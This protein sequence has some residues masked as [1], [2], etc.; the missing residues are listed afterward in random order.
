MV[1]L[2]HVENHSTSIHR[3][4]GGVCSMH[5]RSSPRLTIHLVSRERDVCLVA[6][7]AVADSWTSNSR[8]YQ[9]GS[10]VHAASSHDA[11]IQPT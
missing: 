7:H 1:V 9:K 4:V 6:V 8:A 3:D 2:L 11:S 10:V 5:D